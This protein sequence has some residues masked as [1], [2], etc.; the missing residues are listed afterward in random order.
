MLPPSSER[1]GRRPLPSVYVAGERDDPGP[2]PFDGFISID[3]T[4]RP[5]SN[6]PT[7]VGMLANPYRMGANGHDEAYR[8]AVVS[9]HAAWAK[10]RNV[11]ARNF[12]RHR[13]GLKDAVDAIEPR[14]TDGH[15]PGSEMW[16]A[17]AAITSRHRGAR[18]IRLKCSPECARFALGG[19]GCHGFTVKAALCA[20]LDRA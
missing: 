3:I 20:A 6:I 13:G 10:A 19:S 14:V 11:P 8:N 7:Y 2:K 12:M 16:A 15:R 4:R 9:A 18:V 1:R 5:N 17:V